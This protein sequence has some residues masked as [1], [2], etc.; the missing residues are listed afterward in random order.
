MGAAVAV[1][2]VNAVGNGVGG[3]R[4]TVGRVSTGGVGNTPKLEQPANNRMMMI[5]RIFTLIFQCIN[6]Y[7]YLNFTINLAW[8]G[9]NFVKLQCNPTLP[10]CKPAGYGNV[11]ILQFITSLFSST[12]HQDD[13]SKPDAFQFTRMGSSPI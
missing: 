6:C 12:H 5:L 11:M 10:L 2:G 4:V 3:K 9:G 1:M 7:R 13:H 8:F